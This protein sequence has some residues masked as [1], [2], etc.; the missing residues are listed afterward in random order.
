MPAKSPEA[1]ARKTAKFNERR[2]ARR[3]AAREVVAG[4]TPVVTSPNRKWRIGPNPPEMSK[5]ELRAM[6]ADAA[7]NTK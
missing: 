7:A 1:I 4:V 6:F 3:K 5:S 2:N